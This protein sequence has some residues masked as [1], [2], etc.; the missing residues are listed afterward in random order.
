MPDV[1]VVIVYGVPKNMSQLYQVNLIS[2]I[3]NCVSNINIMFV[4]VWTSWTRDCSIVLSKKMLI[5]R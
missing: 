2:G 3:S 5:L 1:D 4:V